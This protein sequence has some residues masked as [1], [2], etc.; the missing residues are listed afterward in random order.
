M[1][2][3]NFRT[4]SNTSQGRTHSTRTRSVSSQK[5]CLDSVALADNGA[6]A[7][8]TTFLNVVVWNSDR[9]FPAYNPGNTDPTTGALLLANIAAAYEKEPDS[10]PL[11]ANIERNF[12][13][14]QRAALAMELGSSRTW[15]QGSQESLTDSSATNVTEYLNNLTLP[16]NV[17][18]PKNL[19][20][21]ASKSTSVCAGAGQGIAA[22]CG[23]Q[24]D[25]LVATS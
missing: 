5:A 13:Y 23:G 18:L 22:G 25:A 20:L 16:S 15:W 12:E 24:D 10:S 17:T 19:T 8:D 6:P 4:R 11:K 1:Q 14:F 2:R 7:P 21:S 3:Q 9:L